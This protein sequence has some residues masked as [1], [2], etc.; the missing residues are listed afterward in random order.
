M[1]VEQVN[2]MSDA[3]TDAEFNLHLSHVLKDRK[4]RQSRP[5]VEARENEIS[6]Q[7]HL[8]EGTLVT[9][10]PE[11]VSLVPEW[12]Q[13]EGVYDSWPSGA[14]VRHGGKVWRNMVRTTIACV[15]G[16]SDC[17]EEVLP[18]LEDDVVESG[19]EESPEVTA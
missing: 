7:F 10:L 17:W 9:E 6:S 15:P 8:G 2:S 18:M 13:P 14:L 5:A 3:L 4:A 1:G 16:E 19:S 11:D 12:C